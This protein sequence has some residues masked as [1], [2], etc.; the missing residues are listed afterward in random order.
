[1][2]PIRVHGKYLYGNVDKVCTRNHA[3]SKNS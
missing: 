3:W 1:M 2:H